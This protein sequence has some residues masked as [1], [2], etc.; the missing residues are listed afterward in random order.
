MSA[1]GAAMRHNK[2]ENARSIVIAVREQRRRQQE[3]LGGKLLANEMG[4]TELR[5]LVDAWKGDKIS[6]QKLET[7]VLMKEVE[8]NKARK[9]VAEAR[10][11]WGSTPRYPDLMQLNATPS[12]LQRDFYS[13]SKNA[14]TRRPVMPKKASSQRSERL[15]ATSRSGPRSVNVTSTSMSSRALLSKATRPAYQTLKCESVF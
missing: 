5:K 15:E 4:L 11:K 2:I 13:K 10:N 7:V 9:L 14:S 1:I 12:V 8:C 6:L 3:A